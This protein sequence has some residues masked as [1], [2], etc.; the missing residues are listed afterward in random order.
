MTYRVQ[1]IDM[2]HPQRFPGQ[3]AP[4]RVGSRWVR[5]SY[6]TSGDAANGL[7]PLDVGRVENHHTGATSRPRMN[8]EF[9]RE[10]CMMKRIVR[11]ALSFGVCCAAV[12][13]SACEKK[14]QQTDQA[15]AET[16]SEEQK[17]KEAES[18]QEKGASDQTPHSSGIPGTQ[19]QLE[20]DE[21]IPKVEFEVTSPEDGAVLDSGDEVEVEF[22]LEGYR[23]GKTIGQHIHFVLDNKPYVAHYDAE[24]VPVF[25]DLEPGTH[26]M[27]AF[28]SRHYHLSLKK[29]RPFDTVVFHVEEKSDDFEFDPEKPYLTYSRPKGTYSKEAAQEML[30]DFYLTNAELGEDY[31]VVY[32]VDGEKRGE[33]ST[34]KPTLLSVKPGEHDINLKL[35]DGEGN[36]VQNGG[37]NDTT[38]TITVEE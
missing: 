11:L 16:P 1:P 19:N 13:L 23:I 9:H 29:N 2:Y 12:G 17:Q 24:D 14:Q 36:L 15:E 21:D 5:A 25:E 38:R 8:R 4:A 27:R 18:E 35:V 28:P 37:Y 20:W 22:N 6:L 3:K 32:S 33:L 30:L 26:T 10:D 34:W 7:E 31:R